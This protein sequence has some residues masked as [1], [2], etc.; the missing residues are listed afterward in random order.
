MTKGEKE[1]RKMKRGREMSE[2][3]KARCRGRKRESQ[4]ERGE[5]IKERKG[6]GRNGGER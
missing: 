5:I 3:K 4:K 1:T 6:K 2:N